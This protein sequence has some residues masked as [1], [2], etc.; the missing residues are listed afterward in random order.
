VNVREK[1]EQ[2]RIRIA[3]SDHFIEQWHR[4][5][6]PEKKT[7]IR[8]VLRSAIR[9]KIIYGRSD[10]SFEVF[11]NGTKAILELAP[12]GWIAIT[13]L[14]PDS[15]EMILH[16]AGLDELARKWGARLSFWNQRRRL[17]E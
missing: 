10:G 17:N 15:A 6:K 14:P 4:Y 12:I 1:R 7:K 3:L 8:S 2:V 5:V 9:N 13:V 16:H 11:I